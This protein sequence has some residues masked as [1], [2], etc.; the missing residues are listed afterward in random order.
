MARAPTSL[1][2]WGAFSADID[3]GDIAS[4]TPFDGDTDPSPLPG[5]VRALVPRDESPLHD[6]PTIAQR[7]RQ[8]L[9]HAR[10][11]LIDD[12]SRL[13][14]IDQTDVVTEQLEK[15]LGAS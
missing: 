4:V 9:P 13:V 8:Q 3:S 10:V 6:G 7:F 11:E 2:H 5:P 1:T 15:F 14:V 12:A